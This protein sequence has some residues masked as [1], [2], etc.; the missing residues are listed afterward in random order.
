[1]TDQPPPR[2]KIRGRR[3]R[4]VEEYLK[5][6]NASEAARRAGYTGRANMTGSRLLT[7]DDIRAEIKQRMSE[8][9]METDEVLWRLAQIARGNLA[10]FCEFNSAGQITSFKTDAIKDRGWLI[11]QLKTTM[12]QAGTN[13]EIKLHDGLAALEKIGKALGLFDDR[14]ELDHKITVIWDVDLPTETT[15]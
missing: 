8:A 15:K 1:M 14:G 3:K 13:R 2:K 9:A 11:A 7:N 5:C 12:T 6:W 4:F 10:E